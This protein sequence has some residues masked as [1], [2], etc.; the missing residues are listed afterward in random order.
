MT[1]VQ[2][3]EDQVLYLMKNSF[4]LYKIGISRQPDNRRIQ[5][6]NASGVDVELIRTF[7]TTAPAPYMERKLHRRLDNKRCNGEWFHFENCEEAVKAIEALL[8]MADRPAALKRKK[9]I[10]LKERALGMVRGKMLKAMDFS[11]SFS[12]RKKYEKQYVKAI[13]KAVL[14]T[15]FSR[16]HEFRFTALLTDSQLEDL[17]T[18]WAEQLKKH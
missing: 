2:Q 9:P 15:G 12:E 17:R 13:F 4:G 5:I 1:Q 14:I 3:H 18:V 6:Q 16:L 11:T 10:C 7:R 8:T